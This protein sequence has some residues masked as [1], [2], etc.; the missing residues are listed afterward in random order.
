MMRQPGGSE[1]ALL[2]ATL[3]PCFSRAYPPAN[4]ACTGPA[5]G[6]VPPRRSGRAPIRRRARRAVCASSSL[7]G[8]AHYPGAGARLNQARVVVVDVPDARAH[9]PTDHLFRR[10]R[11]EQGLQLTRISEL[12]AEPCRPR[13]AA[14]D[15]RHSVVK[16]VAQFVR[17]F[18]GCHDTRRTPNTQSMA[19]LHSSEHASKVSVSTTAASSLSLTCH[20]SPISRPPG[21]ISSTVDKVKHL[22]GMSLDQAYDILSWPAAELDPRRLSLQV[23][24][25]GDAHHLDHRRQGAS[26]RQPR[27]RNCSGARTRCGAGADRE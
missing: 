19:A 21:D 17:L 3:C 4:R 6:R 27:S 20:A 13:L 24:G 12:L 9:R 22:L 5:S 18:G 26:R 14:E 16:L 1:L 10:V 7:P 15:H 11:R 8:L 23:Q 25:A 2:T